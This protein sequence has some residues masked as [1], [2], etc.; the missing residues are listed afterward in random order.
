MGDRAWL[1]LWWAVMNAEVTD[2]VQSRVDAVAAVAR[3]H[4]VELDPRD[5]RAVPGEQMPSVPAFLTW[6]RDSGLWA[7]AVRLRWRQ[8]FR[9]Q[10]DAPLVLLF[11]D[12][13]AALLVGRDAAR[14]VVFLKD[15]RAAPNDPAI[16]VDELRLTQL[17]HGEVLLVR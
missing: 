5:L 3:H 10:S 1:S 11:S 14:D 4:G 17:W 8:L 13:G 7:K 6:L 12:G 16:A 2:R 15:P 9:F